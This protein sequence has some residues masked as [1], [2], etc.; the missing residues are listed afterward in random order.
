MWCQHVVLSFKT[1]V[2]GVFVQSDD[3]KHIKEALVTSLHFFEEGVSR[4]VVFRLVPD[5]LVP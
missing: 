4:E 3:A 1:P 5:Q 2:F